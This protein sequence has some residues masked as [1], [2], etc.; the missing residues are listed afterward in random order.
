M[1]EKHS[2]VLLKAQ[3]L[4]ALFVHKSLKDLIKQREVNEE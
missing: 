1:C 2:V 3:R 4:L